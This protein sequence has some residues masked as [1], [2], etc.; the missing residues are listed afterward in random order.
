MTSGDD[1]T[2]AFEAGET[3]GADFPHEAHVLVAWT[4]AHR[5]P[6]GDAYQRLATG[7]RA[8]AT[9]SGRP[10]AFHET[11][12]RAWFELIA[13]TPVLDDASV[14]F[15]RGLLRRYYSPERVGTSGSSPTWRRSRQRPPSR[16]RIDLLA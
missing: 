13:D 16:P 6:R 2:A 5:H 4:L 3:A 12:T 10:E 7:I 9:R 11:I 8:M 1:V 14:L 15:D